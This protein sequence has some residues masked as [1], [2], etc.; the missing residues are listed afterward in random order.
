MATYSTFGIYNFWTNC[1]A[2]KMVK[3]TEST[4]KLI[5]NEP[6]MVSVR[7]QYVSQRWPNFARKYFEI[8]DKSQGVLEVSR[9]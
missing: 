5:E 4:Q 1:R 7:Q 2:V 3:F 6:N 9:K 8:K